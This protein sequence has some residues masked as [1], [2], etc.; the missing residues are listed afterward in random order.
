MRVIVTYLGLWPAER[1]YQVK[2]LELIRATLS[3]ERVIVLGDI[4]ESRRSAARCAG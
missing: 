4:N 1:R 3:H 2:R